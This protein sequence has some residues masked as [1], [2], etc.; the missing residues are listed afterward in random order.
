[1][2]GSMDTGAASVATGMVLWMRW[3]RYFPCSR[4]F[5]RPYSAALDGTF[6][7]F[8]P[9]HPTKH[10]PHFSLLARGA[11]AFF[12]A[13]SWIWETSMP[14]FLAVRLIVQFIGRR[15]RDVLRKR[16]GTNGFPSKCG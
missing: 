13:S 1:V 8:R 5:A 16:L 15:R 2:N 7:N 11:L 10:F 6:P 9:L 3:L 14:G 12:F 4:L